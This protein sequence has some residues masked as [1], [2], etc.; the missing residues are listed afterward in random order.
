MT[1]TLTTSFMERHFGGDSEAVATALVAAGRAAHARSLDAKEGSQLA[2]D[3]AYGSTFWLALP[4]EVVSRLMAVLEGAIPY[5]PR[6]AQYELLAWEGTAI[7]PVKVM[8]PGRRDH[9]PRVRVSGLRVRLTRINV[10]TAP[11]PTLFD[12]LD[13]PGLDDGDV[14]ARQVA[15]AARSAMGNLA[16]KMVV[17]AY[18]CSPSRGL[19]FVRVGIATLDPEGHINFSDS[20]DLSLARPSSESDR[21][22]EVAG[23][24][25]DAGPRPK[26]LLRALGEDLAA[27][28]NRAPVSDAQTPES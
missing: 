17:V 20:E 25:F 1:K 16:D 5:P 8:E 4:Q 3:H 7:L 10:P 11:E 2:S 26:P 27:V 9:R 13:E 19:Q 15:E 14:A 6:G 23:D 24:A 22:T 28:G 12:D 21:P 18:L